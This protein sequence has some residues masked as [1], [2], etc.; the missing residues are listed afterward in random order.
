MQSENPFYVSAHHQV[1]IEDRNYFYIVCLADNYLATKD[2]SQAISRFYQSVPVETL[3]FNLVSLV[4]ANIDCF[5]NKHALI[6]VKCDILKQIDVK[7]SY[8]PTE[9]VC[10]MLESK[11][12]NFSAYLS[13][14]P[15]Y[16]IN[17]YLQLKELIQYYSLSE[18][19]LSLFIK[20][21]DSFN[22]WKKP[23]KAKPLMINRQ[24]S[25]EQSLTAILLTNYGSSTEY[26]YLLCGLLTSKDYGYLILQNTQVLVK[27]ATMF[28]HS[29]VFSKLWKYA[30]LTMLLSQTVQWF[31]INNAANLP[32][33][34][35]NNVENNPY[36]IHIPTLNNTLSKDN[37]N[38]HLTVEG[39]HN[40]TQL[41]SL[42]PLYVGKV[43]LFASLD[44]Q[45]TVI[46]GDCLKAIIP[47]LVY[48]ETEW[49]EYLHTYYATNVTQ[50]YCNHPNSNDYI[51]QVKTL[52]ARLTTT[53]DT[54]QSTT[55]KNLTIY[56][57]LSTFKHIFHQL[58][59]P[60]SL[61]AAINDGNNDCLKL[62]FYEKY[63]AHKMT[64][65][66][67][68][69]QD[70]L[71][72]LAMLAYCH[73]ENTQLRWVENLEAVDVHE[74]NMPYLH[75]E[76]HLEYCLRSNIHRTICIKHIAGDFKTYI[77]RTHPAITQ[78]YY[79]NNQCYLSAAAITAYQTHS[80]NNDVAHH[81]CFINEELDV[82]P[83]D[84]SQIDNHCP[85]N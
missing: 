56:I 43:D 33:Y 7:L 51:E 69:R 14:Y 37:L 29:P 20:Q 83:M 77:V 28:H 74:E 42:I 12:E 45:F 55:Q 44:C 81:L 60:L 47:K 23:N 36:C 17:H 66:Q 84:Q 85:K 62:Y 46:T 5:P 52:I 8:Q 79:D 59:L 10:L 40:L 1:S 22:Y 68:W 54:L 32:V 75:F 2:N 53:D 50:I 3:D 13:M 31:E 21:I 41:N 15:M 16:N 63:L 9:L 30:W 61:E 6:W 4:K 11:R 48:N 67:K 57:H 25:I 38:T 24:T 27:C 71:V 34:S 19:N 26:Y 80:K 64:I 78:T 76:E 18:T 49:L 82:V 72:P 73:Y 39:I 70:S 65:N 35:N 58:K